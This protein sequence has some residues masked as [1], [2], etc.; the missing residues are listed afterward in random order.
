MREIAPPGS[1]AVSS[2][3]TGTR[4]IFSPVSAAR[5]PGTTT[6][7]IV[8]MDGV[9]RRFVELALEA[10]G[11]FQVESALDGAGALDILAHTQ[12]HAIIADTELIDMNGLQLFRRLATESRLRAIP[13]LFLSS[14][15]RVAT[16]VL[17]FEEGVDDFLIKP[18]DVRE[19]VAR[20]KAIVERRR[21]EQEAVRRRGYM[22]AGR[23]SALAFSDLVSIIE[24]ARRS[25]IVA[26]IGDRSSGAVYFDSGRIV[27]ASFG[28]LVGQPAFHALMEEDDAQFEF[29]QEPCTL[30]DNQRTIRRSAAA[31]ILET[32][33]LIDKR[34]H[35]STTLEAAVTAVRER[36][37]PT[38]GASRMRGTL[39]IPAPLLPGTASQLIHD[40]GDNF[41]LGDACLYTRAALAEWTAAEG[42][43]QRVHVHLLAEPNQAVAGILPLAGAPSERWVVS[44]L[45]AEAK[46]LGLS[47]SLRHELLVDLIHLD[48]FHP[49]AFQ[50]S[51]MRVPSLLLVAPPD[52]DFL[53]IGTKARV[54]LEQLLARALPVAVLGVGNEALQSTLRLLPALRE[55]ARLRTAVGVLGVGGCDLRR[56]LVEG[57][58]LCTTEEQP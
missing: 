47:F 52:G 17:A 46:A 41:A 55:H 2:A 33:E 49:R 12:I 11:T 43:R 31:L 9:S 4:E 54:E 42:G 13:F 22:L 6:V 3:F 20:L 19:L 18:C 16:R 24:L 40:V 8:D 58:R 57:I 56:L 26:V 1:V 28:N 36:P 21:R 14:D 25:G 38:T 50:A 48:I 15:S 5:T 44:S 30:P 29:S 35:K 32:A 45:S 27:H 34:K 53:A 7:L 23:F 37:A 51:L 39:A 10:D